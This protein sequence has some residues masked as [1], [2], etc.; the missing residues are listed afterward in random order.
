[1]ILLYSYYIPNGDNH[2]LLI[3]NIISKYY[4]NVN[5]IYFFGTRYRSNKK[6]FIRKKRMKTSYYMSNKHKI[7]YN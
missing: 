5:K 4:R 2:F 7:S 6:S 3:R 1:M